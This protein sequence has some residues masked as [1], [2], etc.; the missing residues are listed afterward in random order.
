MAAMPLRLSVRVP[1]LMTTSP[2]APSSI[3]RSAL[4][5][6]RSST[7]LAGEAALLMV[8]PPS[9]LSSSTM[10]LV[11]VPSLTISVSTMLPAPLP[12]SVLVPLAMLKPEAAAPTVMVRLALTADR[13]MVSVPPLAASTTLS[14]PQTSRE[15]M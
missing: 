1:S 3:S 10:V 11:P 9:Q 2:S 4:T 8:R 5:A 15:M 6:D 13:S 14:V 7:A 12:V